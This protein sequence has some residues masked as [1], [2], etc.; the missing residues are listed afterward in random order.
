MKYLIIPLFLVLSP[1]P[2]SAQSVT[3]VN[4]SLSNVINTSGGDGSGKGGYISYSIG[5]SY[6]TSINTSE[7][8]VFQGV[9]IP[10]SKNK[11]AEITN[12]MPSVITIKSYPNP[13]TDYF[14]INVDNYD[15]GLRYEFYNLQGK[16]I[17][18]DKIDKLKTRVN[19]SNLQPAVYMLG[20]FYKNTPINK[21]KI[22]KR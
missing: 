17:A 11:R 15:E 16:L 18:K 22:I 2:L 4:T 19:S 13:A 6:Y 8:T 10:V 5:Q 20:I 3:L 14:I 12:S 9:Q 7:N 1:L 21:L